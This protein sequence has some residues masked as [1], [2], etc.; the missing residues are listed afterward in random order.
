MNERVRELADQAKAYAREQMGHTTNTGLFS[1]RVFED[2]FAELIV[3]E[4]AEQAED[5]YRNFE[6]T[7]GECVELEAGYIIKKHFGVQ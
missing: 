1:A 7:D 3:L 4:C 2:K 5:F 6:V